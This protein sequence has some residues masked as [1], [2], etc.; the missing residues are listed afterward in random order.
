[1]VTLLDPVSRAKMRDNFGID[2]A[3]GD[4][5]LASLALFPASFR[6]FASYAN[7][8]PSGA[9]TTVPACL[10]W[11]FDNTQVSETTAPGFGD[12]RKAMLFCD[13]DGAGGL[14]TTLVVGTDYTPQ[15]GESCGATRAALTTAE[16]Q[17]SGPISVKLKYDGGGPNGGLMYVG[18][19]PA[20]VEVLEC[21]VNA[22]GDDLVVTYLETQDGVINTALGEPCMDVIAIREAM[23]GVRFG[24]P[25][26]I[27]A[28][29][30]SDPGCLIWDLEGGTIG[31]SGQ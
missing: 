26:A 17:T 21:N 19:G 25:T 27:P 24:A 6:R 13:A 16:A 5:C 11:S 9:T 29:D 3:Q 20:A 31:Q 14:K 18:Q 1:V 28:G 22:A 15:A 12:R 23:N 7:F 4:P 2:I 30:T 10:I 8:Q